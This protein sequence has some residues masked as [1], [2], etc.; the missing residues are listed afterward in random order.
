MER[1]TAEEI[2]GQVVKPLSPSERLKLA[3]M[4]LNDIPPQAIVD[5]GEEWTEEDYHDFAVASWA[6]I[7]Q[8]LEEENTGGK[9]WQ[10]YV[11]W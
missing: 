9:Q 10:G 2:Y 8:R 1:T 6:Y 7:T 3:T 11:R 4:I 5:Y